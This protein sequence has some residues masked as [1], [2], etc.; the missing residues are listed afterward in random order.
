[1]IALCLCCRPSCGWARSNNGERLATAASRRQ[2]AER[3]RGPRRRQ[4]KGAGRLSAD[5]PNDHALSVFQRPSCGWGAIKWRARGASASGWSVAGAP[6]FGQ[7]DGDRGAR[8]IMLFPAPELQM[9]R[10]FTARS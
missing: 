7:L 5:K 10:D 2:P 4:P 3:P 1:M 9:G 6:S 8:S